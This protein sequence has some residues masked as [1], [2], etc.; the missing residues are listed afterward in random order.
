VQVGVQGI[1][2]GQDSVRPSDDPPALRRESLESV[3]A[4]NDRDAELAFEGPDAGR[5][6]GLT[7]V[8]GRR[9]SAEVLLP[10]ECGEVFQLP[11]LHVTGHP[12]SVA[13]FR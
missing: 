13:R 9:G 8:T 12:P 10:G 2:L 5:Q 11:K 4:L 7:R 6:C 3:S 1:P